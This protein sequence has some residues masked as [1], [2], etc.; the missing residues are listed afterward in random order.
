MLDMPEAASVKQSTARRRSA[1]IAGTSAAQREALRALAKACVRN[2]RAVAARKVAS[3]D[4]TRFGQ[5]LDL[6]FIHERAGET[7]VNHTLAG[8]RREYVERVYEPTAKGHALLVRTDGEPPP[9]PPPLREEHMTLLTV[10][11]QRPRA[12]TASAV[13]AR[14]GGQLTAQQAGQRLSLL[15]RHHMVLDH[16]GEWMVATRWQITNAGEQA[17][18]AH[19]ESGT[20]PSSNG[21]S[22]SAPIATVIAWDR[23]GLVPEHDFINRY[24]RQHVVLDGDAHALCGTLVRW[25]YISPGD[26]RRCPRCFCIAA[27]HGYRDT[28]GDMIQDKAHE[29]TPSPEPEM[30]R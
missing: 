20:S 19:I 5:L 2:G 28:Y 8:V 6:G 16:L 9:P 15:A 29:T 23:I 14:A 17:L 13:A 1:T 24:S 30:S 26:R 11:T 12:M 3:R 18:A 25:L 10:L 4:A 21:L 22:M 7:V 27:K